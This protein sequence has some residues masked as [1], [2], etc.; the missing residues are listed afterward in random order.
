[1]KNMYKAV[2]KGPALLH[3]QTFYFIILHLLYLLYLFFIQMFDHD[4]LIYN[5]MAYLNAMNHL[6]S[7]ELSF[8]FTFQYMSQL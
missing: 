1:M 7:Y 8:T 4:L 6:H 3:V 5:T 2:V